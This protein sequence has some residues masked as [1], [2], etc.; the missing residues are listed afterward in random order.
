VPNEEKA[1]ITVM[2][3]Q[4]LAIPNTATKH[5]KLREKHRID[6]STILRRNQ[7]NEYLTLDSYL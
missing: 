2:Q 3:Q 1:K 5:P 6:F 4:S 7:L